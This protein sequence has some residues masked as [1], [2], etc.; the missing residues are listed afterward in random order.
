[1][2]S[3]FLQGGL[4]NQLFQIA[5]G[6]AHSLEVEDSFGLQEG[7]HHLPLQ[8]SRVEMYKDIFYKDISFVESCAFSS[9]YKESTFSY[10]K[11]PHKKDLYLVGYFQ[12]EQY[13]K[14]YRKEILKLFNIRN[15]Q[16][17]YKDLYPNVQDS[18]CMHVRRG[19]Y[20]KSSDTHT[21]LPTSY[22]NKAVDSFPKDF[23]VLVFS[24]DIAHCKEE[25]VGDRFTFVDGNED[26]VDLL[27]MS[28]CKYHIIANSSFSWWGA[29]LSDNSEE[30]MYPKR[31]FGPLG[32][33][34]TQDLTPP[35]WYGV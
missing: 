6:Y 3:V 35:G 2:I 24:D 29:W 14:K 15:L 22:Y 7:Q 1:M 20:L 18:I 34:D 27:V 8:G 5:C 23:P 16:H 4:G 12:S 9:V 25:W 26:F 19:D 21:N 33:K 28:Q 11:L 13:F 30:V 31:W 10:S 17:K 32:P